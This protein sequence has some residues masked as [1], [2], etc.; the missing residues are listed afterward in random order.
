MNPAPRSARIVGPYN[1][2][3][4]AVELDARKH[5]GTDC[6]QAEVP[7]NDPVEIALYG[8][9]EGGWGRGEE[10]HRETRRLGS[11]DQS[12]VLTVRELPYFVWLD[13]DRKLI[14]PPIRMT[15]VRIND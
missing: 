3:E 6:E 2:Q 11:G 4:E 12:V 13:P 15:L 9:E 7:R 14:E 1:Y 10:I 5:R 8:R